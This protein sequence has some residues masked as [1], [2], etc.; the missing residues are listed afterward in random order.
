MSNILIM[1]KRTLDTNQSI[2][3]CIVYRSKIS[4]DNRDCKCLEFGLF[5]Y[6]LA[7]AAT[8]FI[9]VVVNDSLLRSF[10]EQYVRYM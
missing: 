10:I 9:T 8:L 7:R 2:D 3:R 4:T 1:L 6:F 5:E